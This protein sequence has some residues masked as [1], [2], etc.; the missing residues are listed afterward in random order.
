MKKKTDRTSRKKILSERTDHRLAGARDPE[1][2]QAMLDVMDRAD[3]EGLGQLVEAYLAEISRSGHSAG[4]QVEFEMAWALLDV[5]GTRTLR[6]EQIAG[7]ATAPGDVWMYRHGT[8]YEF[9]CKY[10]ENW[11]VERWMD[12]AITKI[13]RELSALNPGKRFILRPTLDGSES[14]WDAFADYVIQNAGTWK[15]DAEMEVHLGGNLVGK[16]LLMPSG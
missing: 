11:T 4:F 16:L 5:P 15:D 9:A 12:N 3:S 8:Q 10:S 14:D 7:L 1:V 6:C 13:S 2:Q